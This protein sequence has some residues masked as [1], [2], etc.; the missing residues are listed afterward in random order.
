MLSHDGYVR[1]VTG[2]L[3]MAVSTKEQGLI[4]VYVPE[5]NAAKSALVKELTII[6]AA[7]LA[8]LVDYLH[9]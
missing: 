5:S 3:P 2:V 8:N 7:R 9:S 6:L 4:T 1:R